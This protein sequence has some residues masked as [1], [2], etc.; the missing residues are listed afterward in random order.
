MYIDDN[1]VYIAA[2]SFDLGEQS[3]AQDLESNDEKQGMDKGRKG[4]KPGKC[5]LNMS[6]TKRT[7]P[8]L[9]IRDKVIQALGIPQTAD[10]FRLVIPHVGVT[11]K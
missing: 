11:Y 9:V 6:T 5:Y 10:C 1:S 8:L 4:N 7:N 2:I 3:F